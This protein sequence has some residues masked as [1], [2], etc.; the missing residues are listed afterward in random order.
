MGDASQSF[1]A[2]ASS[3]LLFYLNGTR[4]TLDGSSID[5]DAT[6][7]DFIRSQG[8]GLTGT[9][10]GCGEGGCGAC[11]VVVQSRHPRTG[12]LQHLAVNACLAP[13]ISVDGKH[14]ITV[15]G[16]GDSEN[17][18]PLQERMWKMSGSQCGFCTPGIIMSLYALLRTAYSDPA[19]LGR[20]TVDD[21]ELNGALDGNL[22]RC[23][24]YKT[25][26]DSAKTFVGEYLAK[27][28]GRD[29]ADFVVPVNYAA[30]NLDPGEVVEYPGSCRKTHDNHPDATLISPG[31]PKPVGCGRADC[32]QLSPDATTGK[33]H[34]YFPRFTFRP[35][36]PNTELIFPPSLAAKDVSLR[37]LEFGND[38]R[39]WFR[40]VTLKQLVGLVGEY[41][42]GKG[43]KLVGGSSEIQIEVKMKAQEYPISI[44]VAD[45]PELYSVSP[46]TRERQSLEFGANLP[47]A[48]LEVVCRGLLEQRGYSTAP[49]QAIIA[50][51]RYFAGWQIRNVASA[52]GNIAT[53]SPISDLNPVFV[54]VGA[55][56]V[57]QVPS[58][59]GATGGFESATRIEVRMDG[60][61]DE[62]FFVGYRRTRLPPGAVIE[63]VVVPLDGGPREVVKAYK[64][65]KRRDDDIAIVTSC[66]VMR[67]GEDG[68][69][70]HARFAYGGMAAWTITTPKTQAFVLGKA[71]TYVTLEGA[72]EVLTAEIDL[73]YDVP[74]GMSSFRKTLALSFLFKFWNAVSVELGIPL[75]DAD[76][77]AKKALS[78]DPEDIIGSI[79]RQPSSGRRD[80]SDPYAQDVVGK[81]EPHLSGLKHTT[82][83]AVYIDDMPR[84]Q[85]E[86]YG[87]LVL[88]MRARAK[89]LSIHPEAALAM[90][91]VL[92]FVC[93]TDLPT[94]K[95]N[96]W[97]TVALDEV[98]FAVDEVTAYAQPIGMVVAT[99]KILAQKAA[100]AVKVVYEDLGPPILTI[101]D[102]LEKNSFHEQ[103]DRRIARG[104]E[105][106]QM[107][108]QAEHV[109]EGT[110]RMGGQE[111]ESGE[112]EVFSSTQALTDCQHWVAQVTGVPRN[113]IVAR[114]KRMGGGFGGKETR[115][116][117]LAAIVALAAKKSKRPVRC[118]LD[119]S[120]DMQT[121]GQRH[122]FL[123]NWKVGYTQQ[124][125]ITALKAQLYA[126]AGYSLD[127]SGGVVDRA[128]AHIENCFYIPNVDVRGRC[129]KTNTVSNTAFRGFGGPQG[130]IVAEHYAEV[131]AHQLGLDI[132]HVRQVSAGFIVDLFF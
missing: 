116:S 124:G 92:T 53:A 44:Y 97:G 127:I 25:V 72:L 11:T 107:L 70:N 110:T 13:I 104:G 7:L 87:A 59:V 66:F 29:V 35:Y 31:S 32:C 109:V 128:L 120:E 102:A 20:L 17:P 9:K 52:A 83:E 41:G 47:L 8:P 45:I 33:K 108:A 99:T 129:C 65:A 118:M 14:V 94:P 91:G 40:P 63:K 125:K 81:Q 2:Q 50:Q 103:Y 132:D 62:K 131:V 101:E 106:D 89:I 96:W 71:F 111:L 112:M 90:P 80:N 88:S 75:D 117:Q 67:V 6:L 43:V 115:S 5:P 84:F 64:Q 130:M 24:G 82:G 126:N 76:E 34:P 86:G 85:N 54:A 3:S 49:L 30:A 16:L 69:I 74:G 26:L 121:T 51:L 38:E 61:G 1:S 39:R 23:T 56:V 78:T 68:V 79:H 58:S 73:P 100:R 46:P 28:Q 19:K 22:C 55:K 122:P 12:V 48:E 36:R 15:E 21:I 95:T 10:L 113:R 57:A 4:I 123:V 60:E 114:G 105:I 37:P 98:F 93:H 18:H 77:V 27:A 119:R 42:T